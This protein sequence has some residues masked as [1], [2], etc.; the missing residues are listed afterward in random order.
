MIS[1]YGEMGMTGKAVEVFGRMK[2]D[3][4]V[5]PN[6]Y[7][8]NGILWVLVE[9]SVFILAMA[10]YNMVLR[11]S[12]SPNRTTFKILMRGCSKQGEVEDALQLFDEMSNRGFTPDSMVYNW[13]IVNL[14]RANKMED[15]VKLLDSMQCNK[16]EPGVDT[17]EM[18]LNGYCKLGQMKEAYAVLDQ[19]AKRG[20]KLG[21][22]V[23]SCLI[24]GLIRCKE[25]EEACRWYRVVLDTGIQPDCV[26]YTT[27][28]KG[29]VEQGM[30]GEAFKLLYEMTEKDVKPDR[31][32]Y[33]TLIKGLCDTG[34]LNAARSLLLEMSEKNCFPDSCTYTILICGY[35][36]V[37]LV[38]EAEE[39]FQEMSKKGCFPTVRTFNALI[40]GLCNASRIKDAQIM[41]C[42]MEMGRDTSVFVRLSQSSDPLVYDSARLKEAV[43]RLTQSGEVSKAYNLVQSFINS[44]VVRPDNY[45]YAILINSYCKN[46]EYDRVF[47]LVRDLQARGLSLDAVTYRTIINQLLRNNRLEDAVAIYD[48]MLKSGCTPSVDI[49]HTIMNVF[50]RMKNVARAVNIWLN[51]LSEKKGLSPKDVASIEAAKKQFDQGSIE[52]MVRCLVKMDVD[53]G[54]CCPKVYCIWIAGYCRDGKPDLGYQIFNALQYFDVDAFPASFSSLIHVFCKQN[55]TRPAMEIMDLALRKGCVFSERYGNFLLQRLY[56]SGEKEAAFDLASRIERA[57]YN[58][59]MYLNVRTKALFCKLNSPPPPS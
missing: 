37:G 47:N 7:V 36:R 42:K 49:Y 28:I 14:C 5:S 44:G 30:V 27:M 31:M 39:I 53:N 32:C 45:T 52:G 51:H 11:S 20:F 10:V 12:C 46:M 33:N 19:L 35:C 50:G 21:L 16:I 6:V 22:I 26:L 29:Y 59:N 2:D 18:L 34:Q 9:K 48:R 17:Y 4:G 23:Y 15:A 57:G 54:Y 13:V 55:K 40:H 43:Y 56:Q 3:F 58:L 24:D 8:Y 38:T 25:F 1:G 41:F